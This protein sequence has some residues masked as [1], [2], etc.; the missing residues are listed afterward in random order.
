MTCR[1]SDDE[2]HDYRSYT[3]AIVRMPVYIH[4]YLHKMFHVEHCTY[5]GDPHLVYWKQRPIP[6][7]LF[8]RDPHR[9]RHPIPRLNV[10]QPYALRRPPRLADEL[11]LDADNLAVLADQHHLRL[12]THLRDADDFAVACRGLDVDHAL[13]AAI[14][15]AILVGGSALAVSVFGDGKNERA[16]FRDQVRDFGSDIAL[17]RYCFRLRLERGGHADDVIFLGQVHAAHAGGVASHGADV[18]FVEAN[19][20]SVVRSEEDDLVAV[21]QRGRDQL[22][23]LFDIDGDDAA[24]HHVR[25]VFH[26]G[27]LHRAI[28][29]DKENVPAFFFQVA[30]GEHGTHGF[31]RLQSHQV[32]HVLSLAG[33]GDVGNLIH[34]QPVDAP[35]VGEDQDVGV[36]R[37]DEQ[38]LDEILVARL[39]ARAPGAPAP[40]HAA[41]R[42][43]SALHVAGMADRDRNLLVG[44]QVFEHDLRCFVFDHSAARV[45]V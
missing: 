36:S 15:K 3:T 29:R 1:P 45:A 9:R 22:I 44:D 16:L 35:G 8:R 26:L 6:I 10:Y 4:F 28:V 31:S 42:D 39:H 13:I 7:R 38:M 21:G 5:N 30:H 32:A 14:G 24:R 2:T 23:A 37:G 27:L 33:G 41:G 19:C 11:R 34:L 25:E 12:L 18:V 17:F 43:R 40:L 20:L